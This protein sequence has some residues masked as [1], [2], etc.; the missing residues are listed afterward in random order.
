MSHRFAIVNADDFGQSHGV[1]RGIAEAH[2]QGILTNASL[3][4]RWSAA[5]DAA[6]YARNH[7]ALGVGLHL[8][9]GEWTLRGGEWAPLYQVV[10]I[11]DSRA[12]AGE[13]TRQFEAFERLLNRP[14]AQID[15]HQHVHLSEP[16]RS[17]VC[18]VA[19][20]QGIAVRDVSIPYCGASMVRI[21]MVMDRRSRVDQD[22]GRP[23]CKSDG[24]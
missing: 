21:G 8:D 16:V 13:V 20:R 3:M 19:E 9:L 17:I 11:S 23:Y 1:N 7:P 5:G 22:F 10:D 2:E 15:S 4:V 24:D 14:P 18:E 6:A 12:V